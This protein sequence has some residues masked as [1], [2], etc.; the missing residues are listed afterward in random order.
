M[1]KLPSEEREPDNS[2][3]QMPCGHLVGKTCLM[4]LI[5]ADDRFCPHSWQEMV[6]VVG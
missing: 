3:I 6:A 4:Q 1:I 2:P 5:N